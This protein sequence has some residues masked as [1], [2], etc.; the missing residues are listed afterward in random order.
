MHNDW[1]IYFLFCQKINES[2]KKSSVQKSNWNPCD[3]LSAENEWFVQ[4]ERKKNEDIEFIITKWEENCG[5]WRNKV[6]DET[7][8]ESNQIYQIYV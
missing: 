6:W 7:F 3:W 5:K 8:I 1:L 4:D 2:G